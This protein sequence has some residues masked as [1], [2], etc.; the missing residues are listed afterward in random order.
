MEFNDPR[1]KLIRTCAWE[2]VFLEWFKNEGADP[3]WLAVANERGY[4]T[5]ADWRING[6]ACRFVCAETQWAFY[7]IVEPAKVVVGWFGGPFRTWI[8]KYYDGDKT[9]TFGELAARPDIAAHQG[10]RSRLE[11]YP[12]AS[13]V[14]ALALSDGRI[15]AIEG[16]HRLCALALQ[17]KEG[18]PAPASLIFAIG[19]SGLS[20]LPPVGLNTSKS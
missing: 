10:I 15:M 18:K 7:E 8:E 6:Y 9:R 4:T 17:A 20:E 3:K 12:V 1:I 14:S 19:R 16:M 11:N 2:E 13:V 5:W